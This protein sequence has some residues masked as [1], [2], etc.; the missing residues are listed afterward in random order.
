YSFAGP[1]DR[2]LVIALVRG[3]PAERTE[4]AGQVG[5]VLLGAELREQRLVGLARLPIQA[6]LFQL[7]SCLAATAT[8]GAVHRLG[9]NGLGRKG[10]RQ[11]RREGEENEGRASASAPRG[12]EWPSQPTGLHFS[13]YL[14]TR[15]VDRST[16]LG[17]QIRAGAPFCR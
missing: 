5:V 1:S 9:F 17:G 10:K 11:S 16:S 13:Q 7:L 4:R 12:I 8:V 3:G 6:L 14:Y 15:P 2:P